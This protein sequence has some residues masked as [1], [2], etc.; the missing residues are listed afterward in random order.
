MGLGQLWD[1][2]TGT[3]EDAPALAPAAADA[4]DLMGNAFLGSLF[5]SEKPLVANRG[6]A[7]AALVTSD[8]LAAR[9]ELLDRFDTSG[10]GAPGKASVTPEQLDEIVALYSDVRLGR[11]NLDLDTEGLSAE[12][13][14]AFRKGTMADLANLLQTES[15]R[16]VVGDLAHGDARVEIGRQFA[17]QG[18]K[19]EPFLAPDR[20]C[21]ASH[22]KDRLGDPV[23]WCI[24]DRRQDGTGVDSHVRY[25]PGETTHTDH[26]G[27]VRS[28]VTL[29]HE[30][31]HAWHNARGDNAAGHVDGASGHVDRDELQATG[32]GDFVGLADAEGAVP[33][34]NLYRSERR[35][36]GDDLADRPSYGGATR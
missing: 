8:R 10:A 35:G 33:S 7:D 19:T 25:R 34:E 30:L 23:A 31:V 17:G 18:P 15:G 13:A 2:I 32:L 36:L 6:L 28:D 9:Q 3:P 26:D 1:R 24:D 12:E 21:S 16:R 14:D 29:Y 11:T 5:S 27:D 22:G 4:Q 20:D